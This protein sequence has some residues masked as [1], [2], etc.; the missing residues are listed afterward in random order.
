MRRFSAAAVDLE[1]MKDTEAKLQV[2]DFSKFYTDS[3]GL[4]WQLHIANLMCTA[5]H[6]VLQSLGL[7]ILGNDY[8]YGQ[9]P[10]G[11]CLRFFGWTPDPGSAPAVKCLKP[12]RQLFLFCL[13]QR[14]EE[15]FKAQGI[16]YDSVCE[17]LT[18][19][20]RDLTETVKCSCQVPLAALV[21]CC[22]AMQRNGVLDTV[23]FHLPTCRKSA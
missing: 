17:E 20:T 4:F 16:Q 15:E 19:T 2:D 11:S 7:Y 1:K 21:L 12:D 23:M 8:R 14:T 6:T 9:G 10:T 18:G 5:C 22:G 3:R 13:S